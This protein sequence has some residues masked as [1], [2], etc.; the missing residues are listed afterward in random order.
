MWQ[1][2]QTIFLLLA[3]GLEA[4]LV[5]AP[6]WREGTALHSIG[7]FIWTNPPELFPTL[8]SALLLASAGITSSALFLYRRRTRQI[9]L[10][11]WNIVVLTSSQIL[12]ACYFFTMKMPFFTPAVFPAIAAALHFLAMR[13]IRRDEKRVRAADRLR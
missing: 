10:C 9:R 6:L 1:R 2:I 13:Y 8:A 5:F 11:R 4:A 7:A 12:I 3:L